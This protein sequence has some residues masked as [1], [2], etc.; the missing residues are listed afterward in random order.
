MRL[1]IWLEEIL[2]DGGMDWSMGKSDIQNPWSPYAP[3]TLNLFDE[4]AILN[5]R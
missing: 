1:L 5:L 4:P 3:N 2:Q